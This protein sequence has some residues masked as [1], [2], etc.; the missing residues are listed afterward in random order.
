MQGTTWKRELAIGSALLVAGLLALPP[1]IYFVGVRVV[2]PY[3]PNAGVLTLAESIWSD[4]FSLRPVA[5][6]LVLSPYITVQL[7]RLIRR[8]WRRKNV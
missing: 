7:A 8:V 1:A 3:A 4:F 6:L 5:L 2:G